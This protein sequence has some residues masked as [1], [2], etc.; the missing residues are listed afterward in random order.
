MHTF[1]WKSKLWILPTQNSL[2]VIA[3]NSCFNSGKNE[4]KHTFSSVI[5]LWYDL[6]SESLR[7][8]LHWCSIFFFVSTLNDKFI[9]S[10][11]RSVIVGPKKTGIA[12]S[13]GSASVVPAATA[14]SVSAGTPM[15]SVAT[16]SSGDPSQST[17]GDS[18][19]SEYTH[20]NITRADNSYTIT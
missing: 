9:W 19:G 12:P 2:T 7:F 11:Y 16:V 18:A 5:D 17:S 15:E 10:L 1:L 8:A 6:S 4:W 13:I 20:S 14:S 3:A